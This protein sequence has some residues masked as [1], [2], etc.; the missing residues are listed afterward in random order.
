M[1][2]PCVNPIE[3]SAKLRQ[4]A[5]AILREIK[6]H[7]ILSSYGRVVPTGSYFLDLMMY[8]DID[9]YMS[10]VSIAQIFEIGGRLSRS[11]LVYQ[12]IF[13]KSRIPQ[14]PRGLYLKPRIDYGDWGRPWKID[15]WSLDDTVIDEK[16]ETVR[17]FKERMTVDLQ[18]QI[19]QYK[20]SIL[21]D[22]HRTPT[23]S[24]YF[25]CKAFIEEGLSDFQEVTQ[26]LVDNGIQM[27]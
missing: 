18:R 4:E 11:E 23:Y 17:R 14:L 21:T 1:S 2:E 20:Y 16:M 7:D 6:L 10:R 15:I 3:R 9:L 5:D 8:P 27:G 13:E 22:K 12:V 26:Y 25:V 24:G 19:L